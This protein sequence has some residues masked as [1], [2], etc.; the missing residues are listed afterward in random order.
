MWANLW[1]TFP[2]GDRPMPEQF[3]DKDFRLGEQDEAF[4]LYYPLIYKEGDRV[5]VPNPARRDP[6]K[7]DKEEKFTNS[8]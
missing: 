7:I 3:H 8:D 1:K 6:S 4:D 5:Y 2:Y